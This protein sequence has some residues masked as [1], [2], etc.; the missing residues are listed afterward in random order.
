MKLSLSPQIIALALGVGLSALT[1]SACSLKKK[2]DDAAPIPA[3]TS[4]T[5]VLMISL[6][7]MRQFD[8]NWFI[9]N[10]PTS[11]LATLAAQ[12]VVYKNAYCPFP[13]DSYPGLMAMITGG[14]PK[15]T[16]I[17][18]DD[19]FE[20]TLYSSPTSALGLHEILYD[21]SLTDATGLNIDPV[22]LPTTGASGAGTK[23][24]PHSFLKVNTIFEVLHATGA[25]TAWSDKH[26]AYDIVNGPSGTGVTDLYCPEIR[27]YPG[28]TLDNTATVPLCMTYDDGK[29]TA[30]INQIDGKKSTGGTAQPVPV[31][32]GMNFQAVSVAQKITKSGTNPGSGV[33]TSGGYTSS[34]PNVP[35]GV[36]TP[37]TDTLAAFVHT[38]ASIGRLVAELKAKDLW[39]STLLII[40]AKHGQGGLDPATVVKVDESNISSPVQGVDPNATFSDDDVGIVWLND[41]TKLSAAVAALQANTTLMP[42]VLKIL[43]TSEIAARF[44]TTY[45][46]RLPDIVLISK[47]GVLY[48]TSSKKN[49]DHGGDAEDDRHVICLVVD[50]RTFPP[51]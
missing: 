31:V 1:I 12:G 32:F 33:G 7:G 5:R 30:I 50:F 8:Y 43:S 40:S 9:T 47:P 21:E 51:H 49:S 42:T 35:G 29:V 34:T 17:Y 25:V 4:V 38:D 2:D 41:K 22:Y 28:S 23:I 44:G 20:S 36:L 45:P 16:G 26:P 46:T 13:S 37:N 48:S 3:S 24:Y 18:Y 6:D 27:T 19:S 39:A 11:T 15:T 14:T 10:Y